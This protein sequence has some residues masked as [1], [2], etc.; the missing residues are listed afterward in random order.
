MKLL[1]QSDRYRLMGGPAPDMRA[2]FAR[3]VLEGLSK[4]K[5]T[6]P[7][8]HIYDAEGSQLFEEICGVPEYYL[9]RAEA[10]IFSANAP[11]ILGHMGGE[12]ELVELGSGS[13]EKTQLLIAAALKR[14]R[15]LHY[16][17]IDI[18]RE[19]LRDSAD[20]LLAA[21]PGLHFDG[22]AADYLC[23]LHELSSASDADGPARLVL[24]L[25]SSIGNFDRAG[26]GEF[27]RLLHTELRPQDALLIGVDLRKQKPILDAAYDD[28]AGITARFNK[29]ILVRINNELGG[30]FPLDQF[31][32]RADY[33]IESGR[34]K[35]SLRST[36]ACTVHVTELDKEFVFQADEVIETED[37]YKYSLS[38][39]DKAAQTAGFQVSAQWLDAKERFSVSLLKGL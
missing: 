11:E 12:F 25:G 5:K 19:A 39:I 22:Y 32:Y 10:E 2:E 36:A 21:F 9:T 24:W 1:N 17:P 20:G 13:A 3:D 18:S 26:A 31:E 33:Q 4:G 6:L 29:N 14:Q 23:G 27:L 38:E 37:S 35:M 15:T 30:N 16:R 7:C 28:A 8:R 34:V